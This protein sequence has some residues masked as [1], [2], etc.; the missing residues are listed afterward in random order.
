MVE[1]WRPAVIQAAGKIAEVLVQQLVAAQITNPP[2]VRVNAQAQP[3]SGAGC[4]YCTIAKSLL[5]AQACYSRANTTPR[6]V[7]TYV[8]LAM[9]ALNDALVVVRHLP[10]QWDRAGMQ[11]GIYKILGESSIYASPQH[12]SEQVQQVAV[13]VE[14]AMGMAERTETPGGNSDGHGPANIPADGGG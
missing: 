14:M 10:S 13:L 11:A 6:L 8:D 5:W 4:A 7:S 1:Q 12:L 3:E 2:A 9:Q